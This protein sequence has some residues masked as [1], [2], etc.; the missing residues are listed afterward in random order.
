MVDRPAITHRWARAAIEIERTWLGFTSPP[1]ALR[2]EE[3]GW[4]PESRDAACPRCGA[5]VGPG[6]AD[7]HGCRECRDQRLP[8]DRFLRLGSYHGVLGEIV[9]EVKFSRF[10]TLGHQI[11]RLLGERVAEELAAAAISPD[12]V[13]IVPV[14]ISRRRY[15]ERGIDHTLCTGRGVTEASHTRLVRL[16][17]RSHGPTQLAVVPSERRRNVTGIFRAKR[18]SLCGTPPHLILV[19]DDVR[20]TGATLRSACR[21]VRKSLRTFGVQESSG[22]RIWASA[23]AVADAAAGQGAGS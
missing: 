11:G 19:V 21:S 5:S 20:T 16:L 6:A 3:A 22:I 12:R 14:P 13:W 8:W 23:V 2:L 4:S 10:R 18:T 1:L 7:E 17:I 15:L 9:R